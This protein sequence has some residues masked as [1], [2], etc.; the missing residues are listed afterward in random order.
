MGFEIKKVGTFSSKKLRENMTNVL[1]LLFKFSSL[2]LCFWCL[3]RNCDPSIYIC[4]DIK[5]II[6][7]LIIN[8]VARCS[9][10]KVIDF[11]IKGF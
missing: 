1:F 6:G 3:E 9:V 7:I 11:K 5:I 10:M 2:L 4:N 8:L